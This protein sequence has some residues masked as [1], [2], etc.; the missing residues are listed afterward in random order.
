MNANPRKTLIIT[1]ASGLIGRHLSQYLHK[2]GYK[3]M[4]V[5]RNPQKT[6]QLIKFSAAD[7]S[8]EDVVSGKIDDSVNSAAAFINLA[9]VSIGGGRWTNSYKEKILS[10]R[11]ETTEKV[12]AAIQRVAEP[13]V[14]INS[15]A[16]GFY[17]N[18]GDEPLDEHSSVGSGFLA[19]V[20]EK[21]EKAALKA[22]GTTR[23]VF[24]RK[25]FVLAE[26]SPA[27]KKLIFPFKFFAGGPL[28]NG[29]QWMP[30]I[31]IEDVCR[32]YEFII[33]NENIAGAVNFVAPETVRNSEFMREVGLVLKRPAALRT[34]A[35]AL[36]LLLGEMSDLLL[37]SQRVVPRKSTDNGFVFKYEKLNDALR[38]IL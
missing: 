5:S 32:L 11:V 27:F 13:P 20:A 24:A 28:G 15:S 4:T 30:W 9:G 35:G 26:D 6:S 23:I 1:G 33:G 36:K 8:W 10:S 14:L 12:V 21:W 31:H 18:R 16:T 22:E 38:S 17:G 19:E 2:A 3:I 37:D 25:G 34:P 7:Y 29:N